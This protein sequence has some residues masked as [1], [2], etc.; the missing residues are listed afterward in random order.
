MNA[1]LRQASARL[2]RLLPG[3]RGLHSGTAAGFAGPAGEASGSNLGGFL[4]WLPEHAA[5]ISTPLT[6]PLPGITPE[7]P[8][9]A[10][11]STPPTE[12]TVLENGVRIISE[13]SPVSD[14]GGG[15]GAEGVEGGEVAGSRGATN[16]TQRV[17][18]RPMHAACVWRLRQGRLLPCGSGHCPMAATWG[19]PSGHCCMVQVIPA[20]PSPPVSLH[21]SW[22]TPSWPWAWPCWLLL[23]RPRP[24]K[25]RLRC[26]STCAP[27]SSTLC[28]TQ[29]QWWCSRPTN[30]PT[31]PAS[32]AAGPHGEPG[33]VPQL[34]QHLR[35]A[36][37]QRCAGTG[38]AGARGGVGL[39]RGAGGGGGWW[40]VEAQYSADHCLLGAPGGRPA[41]RPPP[42]PPSPPTQ[43]PTHPP[44]QPPA[45]PPTAGSTALLECLAFKATRH[46]DTLRIMKEVRGE[47]ATGGRAALGPRARTHTHTPPCARQC[48]LSYGSGTV[49][50]LCCCLSCRCAV[51]PPPCTLL[52]T[53]VQPLLPVLPALPKAGCNAGPAPARPLCAAAAGCCKQQVEKFGN[54]IV[55]NASREQVCVRV[56]VGVCWGAGGESVIGGDRVA[57]HEQVAQWHCGGAVTGMQGGPCTCLIRM[58]CVCDTSSPPLRRPEHSTAPHCPPPPSPPPSGA[59]KRLQAGPQQPPQPLTK[60]GS[61]SGC[62]RP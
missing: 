7:Q 10:P 22:S 44:T 28:I 21:V 62:C 23:T 40:G 36:G 53:R 31:L 29:W 43:P 1:L 54:S 48:V 26:T 24:P 13:A 45:H 33:R 11:T 60:G 19:Q 52:Q 14:T 56:R 15:G 25:G 4:K 55:A 20:S 42:P 32:C 46:R 57:R 18:Q 27:P 5:R 8:S 47:A 59:H 37:E 17:Q 39:G 3:L 12:M 49:S 50:C 51:H 16:A 9:A 34:R 2:P 61:R 35:N 58:C 41:T 30:Q 38:G 6:Q